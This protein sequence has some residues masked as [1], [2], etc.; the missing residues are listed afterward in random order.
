MNLPR[1]VESMVSEEVG[2]TATNFTQKMLLADAG[3]AFIQNTDLPRMCMGPVFQHDP[4]TYGEFVA[5]FTSSAITVDSPLH[6]EIFPN[7]FN[8]RTQIR[9]VLPQQAQVHADVFDILGRRVA[10]LVQ[11]EMSVGTHNLTFNASDLSSGIYFVQI[12]AGDESR[13]KRITMIK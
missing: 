2:R 13:V 3:G 11:A 1:R 10:T 7:P 4:T 5:D 6:Y 8:S 12:A 9:L